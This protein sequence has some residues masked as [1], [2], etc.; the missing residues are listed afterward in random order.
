ML[1]KW[2]NKICNAPRKR[3]FIEKKKERLKGV[4]WK[5]HQYATSH[6]LI[7]KRPFRQGQRVFFGAKNTPKNLP[8]SLDL[9]KHLHKSKI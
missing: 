5:N 3:H 8:L 6:F 7:V 9:T 1:K 2:C 4:Y